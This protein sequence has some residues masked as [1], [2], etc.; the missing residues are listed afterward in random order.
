MLMHCTNRIGKFLGC[1]YPE[2]YAT[3]ESGCTCCLSDTLVV[4]EDR[5]EMFYL[6]PP[7]NAMCHKNTDASCKHDHVCEAINNMCLVQ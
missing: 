3:A 5:A 7:F 1:V 4:K 2:P 6:T